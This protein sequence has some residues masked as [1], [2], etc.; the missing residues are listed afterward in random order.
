V[1]E[2][3]VYETLVE[4]TIVSTWAG[5]AHDQ[6]IRVS[7]AGRDYCDPSTFQAKPG[8]DAVAFLVAGKSDSLYTIAG[9]GWGYLPIA[10]ADAGSVAIG[11]PPPPQNLK[12]DSVVNRYRVSTWR[13]PVRELEEA[14]TSI[15]Q[16]GS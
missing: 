14:V 4:A 9:F 3:S 1:R 15:L 5:S 10:E 8:E 6:A 12:H 13:V 11:W 7:L 16:E 2:I